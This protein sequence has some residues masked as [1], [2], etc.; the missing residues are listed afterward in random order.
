MEIL[1]T[2][3]IEGKILNVDQ[4]FTISENKFIII[5]ELF[6]IDGEV[7]LSFINHQMPH[8]ITTPGGNI[9]TNRFIMSARQF[10]LG[11]GYLFN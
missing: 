10:V 7:F 5:K 2:I 3:E 9:Q 11:S 8:I 4:I 1:T 6:S